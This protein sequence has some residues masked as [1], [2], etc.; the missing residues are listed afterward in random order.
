MKEEEIEPDE[1]GEFW[2][3]NDHPWDIRVFTDIKMDGIGK[4]APLVLTFSN[5]TRRRYDSKDE[6]RNM[7]HGK[8]GWKRLHPK[9]KED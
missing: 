4:M 7:I 8:N 6:H 9:V 1:A 3:K 5:G 2:V